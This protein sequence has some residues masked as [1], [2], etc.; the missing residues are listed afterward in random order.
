M[1]IKREMKKVSHTKL[2][3]CNGMKAESLPALAQGNALCGKRASVFRPEGAEATVFAP[4]PC[5]EGLWERWLVPI[6]GG[7][8]RTHAIHRPL[9]CA[10]AA[11]LSAF[12]S[13][14]PYEKHTPPLTSP[15]SLPLGGGGGLTFK[16]KKNEQPIPFSHRIVFGL[17]TPV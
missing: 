16:F 12:M 14:K 7:K 5:G 15:S 9:P 4:L 13:L 10:V 6:Q 3:S 8:N 17:D 1:Q 2:V 11:R